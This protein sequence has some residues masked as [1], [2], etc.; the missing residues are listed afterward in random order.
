MQIS[1]KCP[2]YPFDDHQ[3]WNA[4]VISSVC[5]WISFSAA[6]T[7][8]LNLLMFAVT[9]QKEITYLKR[10]LPLATQEAT[11]TGDQTKS[12]E[13]LDL[14]MLEDTYRCSQPP[15]VSSDTTR[16]A[17]SLCAEQTESKWLSSYTVICINIHPPW[18]FLPLSVVQPGILIILLGFLPF[19]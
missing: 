18:T 17:Y 7:W 11:N 9:R 5:L 12:S 3:N 16:T 8:T 6:L 15:C 2:L 4:T 10:L 1:Q 14:V 13:Q 19:D